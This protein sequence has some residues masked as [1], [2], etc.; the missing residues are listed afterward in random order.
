ML[1]PH[2]VSLQ[3][4]EIGHLT[5]DPTRLST[6]RIFDISSFPSLETLVLH[7]LQLENTDPK[8]A[9]SMLLAPR[10]RTFG[11]SFNINDQ[12]HEY[13]EDF[14]AAQEEWLRKFAF[15]AVARR[16]TLRTIDVRFSPD[17][18]RDPGPEYPW[19]RMDK[20]REELQGTNIL[21]VYNEPLYTK[22]GWLEKLEEVRTRVELSLEELEALYTGSRR[23]MN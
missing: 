7:K 18:W 6:D 20:V 9:A 23:N 8:V 10:L 13:W 14:D 2:K 5:R 3:T 11:Y 17:E 22:D 21:L 1:E 12:V 19:D 4:L 16:S 15:E